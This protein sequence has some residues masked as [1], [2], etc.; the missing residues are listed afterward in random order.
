MQAR[1]PWSSSGHVISFVEYMEKGTWF[2][3]FYNDNEE[4][5][6][7]VFTVSE[8]GTCLTFVTHTHYSSIYIL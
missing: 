7:I 5:Q 3:S 1:V 6:M 2:I 8:Y 4:P